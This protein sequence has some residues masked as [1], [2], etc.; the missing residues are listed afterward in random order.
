MQT[1]K[2][3]LNPLHK[4]LDKVASFSDLPEL[5]QLEKEGIPSTK[6]SK[7]KEK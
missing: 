5:S 2:K 6:N 1:F 3:Y 4:D 7:P